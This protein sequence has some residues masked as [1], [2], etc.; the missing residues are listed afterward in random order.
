M[1]Q[2]W[3][4][5]SLHSCSLLPREVKGAHLAILGVTRRSEVMNNLS[6]IEIGE[7]LKARGINVSDLKERLEEGQ[8]K[9]SQFFQYDIGDDRRIELE[10]TAPI[11][12]QQVLRLPIYLQLHLFEGLA[13]FVNNPGDHLVLTGESKRRARVVR[14][15]SVSERVT[16]LLLTH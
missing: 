6:S 11:L 7:V 1:F 5:V 15:S 2:R 12:M 13:G 8:E 16:K 3:G 14:L 4:I 9:S 10:S